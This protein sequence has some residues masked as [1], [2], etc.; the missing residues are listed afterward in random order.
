ML[1][2]Y[3]TLFWDVYTCWEAN[4]IIGVNTM[5]IPTS[6]AT[7][8]ESTNLDW[9][10]LG[11]RCLSVYDTDAMYNGGYWHLVCIMYIGYPI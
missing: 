5:C 9:V 1:W 8:T 2:D 6:Y 10:L 7:V 3:I 11:L 4:F